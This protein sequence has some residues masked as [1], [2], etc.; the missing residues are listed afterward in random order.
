MHLSSGTEGYI[1]INR[2][3]QMTLPYRQKK[4]DSMAPTPT[5]PSDNPWDWNI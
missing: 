1:F 3:M 4:S 2:M 5:I